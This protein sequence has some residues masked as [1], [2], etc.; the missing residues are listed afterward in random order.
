MLQY[1]IHKFIL[2]YDESKA[3]SHRYLFNLF[4]FYVL[5]PNMPVSCL[6]IFCLMISYLTQHELYFHKKQG[7]EECKEDK[8]CE[9]HGR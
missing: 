4:I 7:R 3:F 9:C 6:L 5:F 8:K 1:I 2:S